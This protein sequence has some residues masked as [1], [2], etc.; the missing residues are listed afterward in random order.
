MNHIRKNPTV[1]P[2]IKLLLGIQFIVF[3]IPSPIIGIVQCVTWNIANSLHGMK[4]Y[5]PFAIIFNCILHPLIFATVGALMVAHRYAGDDYEVQ[6]C[7]F[8]RIS[9]RLHSTFLSV[10]QA[11][12]A[13]GLLASFILN[14]AGV[15]NFPCFIIAISLPIPVSLIYYLLSIFIEYHSKSDYLRI[16]QVQVLQTI[17]DCSIGDIAVPQKEEQVA[18]NAKKE[19]AP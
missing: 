10:V 13:L 11:F 18:P 6:P 12:L 4:P 15:N 9:D 14:I 3:S 7:S 2:T 19:D 8:K 1:S 17:R 5:V 16:E